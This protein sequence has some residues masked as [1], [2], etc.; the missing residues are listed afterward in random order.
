MEFPALDRLERLAGDLGQWQ[1]RLTE[2]LASVDLAAETKIAAERSHQEMNQRLR[3]GLRDAPRH[4][5]PAR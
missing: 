2:R 3:D 4:R 5:R 1:R